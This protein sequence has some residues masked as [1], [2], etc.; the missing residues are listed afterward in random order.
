MLLLLPAAPQAAQPAAPLG[1]KHYTPEI[2]KVNICIYIYIHIYIYT[3]IHPLENAPESPLE[4]PVKNGHWKSIGSP[5]GKS[6]E[7]PLESATEN[8]LEVH[9][10][11]Q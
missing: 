3:Y 1:A 10:K 7:N 4:V 8:P 6:T 2:T 9:R 5:S 11:F